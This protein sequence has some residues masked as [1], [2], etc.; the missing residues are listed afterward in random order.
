MWISLANLQHWQELLN[1]SGGYLP[2]KILFNVIEIGVDTVL[3]RPDYFFAML[4]L[5]E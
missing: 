3:K 5:C 2:A 4:F 1:I